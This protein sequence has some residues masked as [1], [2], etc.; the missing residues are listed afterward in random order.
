MSGSTSDQVFENNNIIL[1]YV[2]SSTC[3]QSN[4]EKFRI[5]CYRKHKCIKDN[6]SI[7]TR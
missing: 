1:F 2:N 4:V 7:L 5:I 3:E 6:A